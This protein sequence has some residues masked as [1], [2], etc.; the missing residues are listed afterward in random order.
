MLSLPL[1]LL[2]W[3]TSSYTFPVFQEGRRQDAETVWVNGRYLTRDRNAS[4][5]FASFYY[6]MMAFMGG[7]LSK[8]NGDY[9]KWSL[10]KPYLAKPGWRRGN[11]GR[12]GSSLC[13]CGFAT[14][15]KPRLQPLS[16]HELPNSQYFVV[17]ALCSE[18]QQSLV[19]TLK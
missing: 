12:R 7:F 8:R 19:K 10:L 6:S 1:L 18:G 15:C 4:L 5:C 9:Q 17:G 14:E 3:G 11:Q 16:Q 13:S 2:L